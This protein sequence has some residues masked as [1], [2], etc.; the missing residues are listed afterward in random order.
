MNKTI[1]II[2][3]MNEEIEGLIGYL[4]NKEIIKK[5]GLVFYKGEIFNK[6]IIYS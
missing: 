2:G 1:G 4:E 6:K 5:A 3:A